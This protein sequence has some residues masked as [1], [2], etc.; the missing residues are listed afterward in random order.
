MEHRR[1]QLVQERLPVAGLLDA[2]QATVVAEGF[3]RDL[4][5]AF[6]FALSRTLRRSDRAYDELSKSLDEL[7]R[8]FGLPVVPLVNW[9]LMGASKSRLALIASSFA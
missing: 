1:G 9:M 8:A 7:D 6:G 2:D 4:S 5:Q 3:D